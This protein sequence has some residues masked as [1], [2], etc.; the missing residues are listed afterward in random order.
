MN[1]EHIP[2]PETDEFERAAC[3]GNESSLEFARRMERRLTVA[4]VAL[5]KI[6]DDSRTLEDAD[7]V[8][9]QALTLTAPKP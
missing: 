9:L 4:L 2:T 8:A 1:F 6:Y 3:C 7:Q 5:K